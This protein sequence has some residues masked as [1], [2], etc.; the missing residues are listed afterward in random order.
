MRP[1]LRQLEYLVG[2]SEKLNFRQCAQDM[3][4]TQPTLSGQI[5]EL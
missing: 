1:S 3:N 2:L 5:K 4:V